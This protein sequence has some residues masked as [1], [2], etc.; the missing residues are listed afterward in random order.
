MIELITVYTLG[1]DAELFLVTE[2]RSATFEPF[3]RLRNVLVIFYDMSSSFPLTRAF[4]FPCR[5]ERTVPMAA[6][7]VAFGAIPTVTASPLVTVNT[8]EGR[9]KTSISGGSGTRCPIRARFPPAAADKI[10]S[11]ALWPPDL[12]LVVKAITQK[13]VLHLSKVLG[14]R[15]SA[16]IWTS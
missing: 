1:H 13:M 5:L 14:S 8:R 2:K 6:G 9:C 7:M 16:S 12:N 4:I 10:A 3:I 15:I 11:R